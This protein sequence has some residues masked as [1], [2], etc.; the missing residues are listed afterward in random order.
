MALVSDGEALVGAYFG[1]VPSRVSRS[2][3]WIHDPEPLAEAT[4]QLQGYMSGSID[5]FDL[6]LRPS[7]TTFQLEVWK[8]L[9][10]IP[11]GTTTTYGRIATEIGRPTG[12]RAVGAAVGS[13]PIG[14]IIP[15]H[16]VIGASGALTGFAGGLDAKIALLRIE[17]I[18]A[19]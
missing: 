7:G 19:L 2:G 15:C 4:E 9:T 13:N 18:T 5:R 3:I 8:A 10:A 17:G 14:V 16:R 6:N 12:S 11:Y 1:E